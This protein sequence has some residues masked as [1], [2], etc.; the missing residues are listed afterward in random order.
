MA[1]MQRPAEPQQDAVATPPPS[2]LPP[3]KSKS[4]SSSNGGDLKALSLKELREKAK[5]LKVD[6]TNVVERSE[7]EMLIAAELTSVQRN[8][9]GKKNTTA[10][11]AD[12]STTTAPKR[13]SRFAKE[14]AGKNL[15][16]EENAATAAAAAAASIT[17]EEAAAAAENN[18]K[19]NN[20][21]TVVESGDIITNAFMEAKYAKYRDPDKDR[22]MKESHEKQL[23]DID[24]L[25]LEKDVVTAVRTNRFMPA[26]VAKKEDEFWDGSAR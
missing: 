3:A 20:G 21:K 16:K 9:G 15:G 25:E 4:S 11:A 13:N 18:K 8:G 19:N 22:K 12:N 10:G 26:K 23:K 24:G 6:Y 1:T 5:T 7:L 2:S 14:F 17:P